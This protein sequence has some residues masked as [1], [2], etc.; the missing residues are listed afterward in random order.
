MHSAVRP[1]PI[2]SLVREPIAA[3]ATVF[4]AF[5]LVLAVLAPWISPYDPFESNLPK[6][7]AAPSLAHWLGT[8][9]LGRDMLSRCLHGL[10]VTLVISLSSVLIGSLIGI[11]IGIC[12][13]MFPKSDGV[14]MRIVDFLLSFPEILIALAIAAILGPTMISII[15]AVAFPT[16]PSMARISRSAA[17]VVVRME[18]MEAG[19]A[20]GLST[21]HLTFRYLLPNCFSSI[22]VI[23]TLRIGQVILVASAL[24]FL[25]LGVQPPTAELGNMAAQ[26]LQFFFLAPQL[27]IIPSVIIMLIVLALNAQGEV[28]RDALDPKLRG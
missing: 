11:A 28:L 1:N 21:W 14:L 15:L 26:G 20:V 22:L 9:S 2:A 19:R 10:R 8:D 23:V 5:V 25:G 6:A 24:S 18:Y 13:V 4:L 7:F 17:L 3:A 12:A 16:I 27:S